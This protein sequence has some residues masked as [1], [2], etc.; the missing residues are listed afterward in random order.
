NM[1]AVAISVILA[2]AFGY[3]LTLIPLVNK[4]VALSTAFG[5][6]LASDTLSIATMEVIDNAVMFSIPGAMG[7]GVGTVLFWGSLIVSLVLAFFAAVPVNRWLL[8]KGRG[9]CLVHQNH[10]GHS[11]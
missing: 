11:G 6:V 2:F 3:L 1:T 7:T 4:G 5:L 9:H 8:S 10:P